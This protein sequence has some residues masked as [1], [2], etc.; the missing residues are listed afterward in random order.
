LLS[1]VPVQVIAWRTVSEMTYNVS[2]GTLNLTHS[3]THSLCR[4]TRFLGGIATLQRKRF[5]LV[6]HIS[7]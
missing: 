6:L 2:T 3:L 1:V 4:L 7:P 5:L